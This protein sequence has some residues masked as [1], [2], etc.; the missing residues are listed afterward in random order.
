M[1]LRIVLTTV[2]DEDHALAIG[3]TLVR[4]HLAACVNIRPRITSLYEWKGTLHEEP[5]LQLVIKT[6]TWRLEELAA[7]LA[8]LH[9]YE[10]PEFVV[11]KPEAAGKAY[12]DWV[13]T[14][15]GDPE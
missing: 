9:P 3:R 10:V 12:L 8:E 7:R 1:H 15:S 5:E 14:Q 13:R 2:P 4:E 6:V 11:V